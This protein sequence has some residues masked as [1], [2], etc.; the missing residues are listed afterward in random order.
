MWRDIDVEHKEE[1]YARARQADA[2]HKK[3]Y[4]DYVYNPLDACN[5]KRLWDQARA[6]KLRRTRRQL[7]KRRV[8]TA[9]TIS[10]RP[11]PA[12]EQEHQQGGFTGGQGV[13]SSMASRRRSRKTQK[14]T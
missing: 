1:Y 3:K 5:Q 11:L 13:A 9:Q 4:P 14:K 8:T 2:E 10:A 7:A 12:Q 6:K